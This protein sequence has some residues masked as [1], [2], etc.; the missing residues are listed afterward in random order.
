MADKKISAL[1]SATT[2]LAGT[3]VLPIVQ[4]STTVKVAVSDLTAGRAVSAASLTATTTLGVTGVSTLTGGAVV[5]GLTVGLGGG[6]VGTNTAVGSGALASNSSGTTNTAFGQATLFTNGTGIQN[7]ASGANALQNNS[8]GSANVAVGQGAMFTSTTASDNTAI[9]TSALFFNDTGASNTALGRYTL[10]SNTTA[11]NNTAVGY[12]AGYLSTGIGNQF[13]GY[14]SGSAV[15]T[16][17][18][19]VILGSYTGSAAPISVTGSN[20]VVLSDG[21]GNIV[22]STKTAQTFALPGGTLSSGTGIAFPATQSASSDA[23]TLDDYEEGTWTPANPQVTLTVTSA[24]YTKIGR[25]VNFECRVA[26]PANADVTDASI[27]G[28][29]FTPSGQ[30]YPVTVYSN[31]GSGASAYIP[32]SAVINL[33]TINQSAAITNTTLAGVTLRITGFYFV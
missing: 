32:G 15:T 19:N 27:T 33:A 21:D 22:A 18:K 10:V 23:N 31:S 11:S 13:F 24:V 20:F 25:C 8:V 26:W 5:Q 17:A 12:Q 16:G 6:A 2:P 14:S 28:L 29:P 7:T 3:E 9:G 1:T 4:S 30:D